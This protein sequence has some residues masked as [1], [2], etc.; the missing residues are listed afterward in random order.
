M[1]KSK[2]AMALLLAS[3]SVTSLNAH[4]VSW[5]AT[6]GTIQIGGA[7]TAVAPTV[8]WEWATG[9]LGNLPNVVGASLDASSTHETEISV[10][11][12]TYLIMGRTKDSF[13]AQTANPGSTPQINVVSEAAGNSAVA[14]ELDPAAKDYSGKLSIPVYDDADAGK[15]VI[16][17]VTVP[18]EAVGVLVGVGINNTNQSTGFYNL[19]GNS[20]VSFLP[21][22]SGLGG[23]SKINSY[24][25]DNYLVD[26]CNAMAATFKTN[27]AVCSMQGNSGALNLSTIMSGT[28]N[29]P[30]ITQNTNNDKSAAIAYAM[31]IPANSKLKLKLDNKAPTSGMTWKAPI[32]VDVTYI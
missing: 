17:K 25:G 6:P 29:S 4:A 27:V 31:G 22:L 11:N 15:T 32:R 18:I 2:L 23:V 20:N 8:E 7:I 16:G 13:N 9:T 1:N 12:A 10:A 21:L 30:L 14:V 24:F 5:G 28:N 26:H 19:L 3:A